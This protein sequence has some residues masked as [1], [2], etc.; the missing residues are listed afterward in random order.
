[1]IV[2]LINKLLLLAY[3]D[4]GSHSVFWY[5]H[6][7]QKGQWET[8]ELVRNWRSTKE[9]Q[10]QFDKVQINSHSFVLP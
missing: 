10:D 1:M 3:H 7:T 4:P 8:P 6:E 5:N 9:T 2:C